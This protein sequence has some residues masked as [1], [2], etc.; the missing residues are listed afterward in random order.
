MTLEQRYKRNPRLA[1]Q[2]LGGKAVLLHYEG[3]R[4]LGLNE[5]G[6]RIWELLDGRRT[7]TEIA[8]LLAR[9]TG[10]P[11]PDVQA[12]VTAFVADLASRELVVQT[13]KAAPVERP[14]DPRPGSGRDVSEEMQ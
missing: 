4:I 10:A 13:G 2:M 6:S 5:T 11:R 1:E 3:R 12:E 7:L 14:R 9:E 8:D